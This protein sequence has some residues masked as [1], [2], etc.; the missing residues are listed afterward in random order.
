M[1]NYSQF[2]SRGLT[3]ILRELG[4]QLQSQ[5]MHNVPIILIFNKEHQAIHN[6]CQLGAEQSATL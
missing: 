3:G 2:F 1:T 6:I 4:F 5:F